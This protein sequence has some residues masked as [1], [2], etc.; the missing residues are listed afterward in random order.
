MAN[1]FGNK[2]M[3]SKFETVSLSHQTVSRRVNEMSDHVSGMLRNIIQNCKYYSLAL[4]ESNDI[5]D[6]SQ[7]IIFIRTIDKDF[8]I[9]E[10]LLQI[11]PLIT[12][13]RGVDIFEALKKIISDFGSFDNCTG[14]ITDGAQSMVG[15]LL[16]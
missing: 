5:S 6:N 9:H 10:E 13:T 8:N 3:A 11:K 14:I 4:D 15:I 7:L 16:V 12:G 1:A 2:E